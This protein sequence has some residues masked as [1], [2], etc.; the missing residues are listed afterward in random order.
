MTTLNTIIFN[1]VLLVS[2]CIPSNAPN[3]IENP[4]QGNESKVTQ[5]DYAGV[6]TIPQSSGIGSGVPTTEF[7]VTNNR[8]IGRLYSPGYDENGR[9]EDI[10][11]LFDIAFIENKKFNY[12]EIGGEEE[13]FNFFEFKNGKLYLFDNDGRIIHDNF[14]TF[15]RTEKDFTGSTACD[16]IFIKN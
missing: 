1:I 14:C 7:E 6:Y 9:T 2:G 15:G 8:I 4:N 16:C 3:E 13:V 5:F 12:K 11:E 10:S